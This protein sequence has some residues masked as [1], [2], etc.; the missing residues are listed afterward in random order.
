MYLIYYSKRHLECFSVSFLEAPICFGHDKSQVSPI[1]KR[2]HTSFHN[3]LVH[4]SSVQDR[5]R[6]WPWKCRDRQN[7]G[8]SGQ[9]PAAP[10]RGD[11][12][13]P[14]SI[15]ST[16]RDLEQS[17]Y[18]P[19]LKCQSP[20]GQSLADDHCPCYSCYTRLPLPLLNFDKGAH[21]FII[22]VPRRM[23]SLAL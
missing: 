2:R 9:A 18:S 20:Q 21:I 14:L 15:I 7:Q 16:L 1:R 12:S 11:G 6:C 13:G 4:S 10:S 23:C 8:T 5:R 22:R 3:D 19:T 17:C